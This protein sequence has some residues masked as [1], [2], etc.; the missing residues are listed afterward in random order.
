MGKKTKIAAAQLTPVFLNK[1]KTVEKACKAIL[2]AGKQS[3][4]L[5]VFPESFI[6]GYPDWLWLIPPHKSIQLN[7]LYVKLVKNAVSIPDDT[8]IR[9]CNAAKKA[10]V[11]VVI[12][13]NETNSESSNTSLYNT[14]L[15]IDN[16]GDTL[17]KHRKLIRPIVKELFMPKVMVGHLNLMTH[18]RGKS[19]DSF[20]GRTSCH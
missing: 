4:E 3:V 13:M 15:F 11:N 5:I 12:G 20:V 9:L 1:D 19:V 18:P 16:N 17:G 8:T 2:D 10:K 6:S 7:E 14:L